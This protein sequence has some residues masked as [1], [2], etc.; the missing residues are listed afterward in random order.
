MLLFVDAVDV[1]SR[2]P[3]RHTIYFVSRDGELARRWCCWVRLMWDESSPD[4][5][6]A[7]LFTSSVVKKHYW[8]L[9]SSVLRSSV[10]LG[11]I[12]WLSVESKCACNCDFRSV[13]FTYIFLIAVF[14]TSDY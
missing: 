7:W 3:C 6:D 5:S 8:L 11:L 10:A 1:H 4:S 9:L 12:L 14:V 13:Q 2:H